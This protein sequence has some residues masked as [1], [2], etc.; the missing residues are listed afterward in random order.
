M[1][2]STYISSGPY[3]YFPSSSSSYHPFAFFNPE[4]ASSNNTFS[5]DPFSFPYNMPNTHHYHAPNPETVAN[6][7]DCGVSAAMF[8][9]DVSGSN[10]G[11]SN[12]MAKKPAPKKDRHSKIYTSQGL[13]DR[14]VRLSIEIARKFFDLQDMLGFDKASNTLEWLFNKSKKAMKELARS[15]NSSSGVVANSF[16]SSDSECE[17]VSMI[18]QDSIDAT[19]EGV[20]VDSNDRKL[21]RAKIKESREK[22]RARAR[23]RT[24]KKMFNTSIM[25]KKCPAIENPQ[26][27]NQLRPPFHHPE[28]SA[29]S[30]N[31]K[32]LPSHHHHPHLLSNEIPRD[33]FNL[34][35]ESIVIK[36]KLKQPLISSSH[37]NQN[38]VIPKESNFNNN[39]EHH[40]FPILS[41]NLDANNGANS[42]SNFCS[43]TNMN[44]STG[45]QIFGKSWE[46]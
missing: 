1:F 25:K 17:V 39:T 7:A 36:R 34:F 8:K 38:H 28:N 9:N 21:K 46:E 10:F 23:E 27:F 31:N 16:S 40:S 4:N 15:K 2:P 6:F 30:P 20:V 41:P 5:H 19:P 22:A 24:N 45:L 37:H 32:L 18:N 29:K 42:R 3:P 14:R 11:F 43:I 26:M 13:R 12:F 35:E 33:D 44:L